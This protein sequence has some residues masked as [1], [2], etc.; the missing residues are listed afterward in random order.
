MRLTLLEIV[1]HILNKLN[2]DE[3][4][5]IGDTVES[6]QIALE[7]QASFYSMLDDIQW[8]FQY[9]LVALEASNDEDRPTH[10][11]VPTSVDNFKWIRYRDGSVTAPVYNEVKYLSPEEF[12]D[13]LSARIGNSYLSVQDYSGAYFPIITDRD[14][15]YYTSFDDEYIVFD[16]YNS[17]LDDTLQSSKVMAMGQTIPT[18]VMEDAAYPDIPTKYFPQLLAEATAACFFY[19]RQTASPVDERRARRSFV[20]HQ[21]AMHRSQEADK[22]IPDFGR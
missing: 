1:Q 2:G 9:N 13:Y 19:Q 6:Y 12:L 4:N 16:S 3:V 17:E 20:R 11:R 15:A 14:P 8:P 21:N 18:F 22:Q 7:V 10:M 5:S